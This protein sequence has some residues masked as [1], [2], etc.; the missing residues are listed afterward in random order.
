MAE[1][2]A[3][4]SGQEPPSDTLLGLLARAGLTPADKVGT[5]IRLGA[6][7]QRE[8]LRAGHISDP[9]LTRSV[10][11]WAAL[12]LDAEIAAVLR[13]WSISK[14]ALAQALSL[15][16]IPP[17]ADVD[18][19]AVAPQLGRALK[20]GLPPVSG[21]GIVDLPDLAVVILAD[22]A[23]RGG[24]AGR[25]L[26]SA[27]ADVWV[28]AI[29]LDQA[30]AEALGRPPRLV[31]PP[32]RGVSEASRMYGTC[33]RGAAAGRCRSSSPRPASAPLLP[34][35]QVQGPQRGKSLVREMITRRSAFC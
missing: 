10:A 5:L 17:P 20:G 14:D 32:R 23:M 4:P 22:V 33:S 11:L 25:R 19:I 7:V 31:P 13:L 12:H 30:L 26:E 35:Q 16:E 8:R 1:S 21:T 9:E 18:D 24:L 34:P 27:G 28:A 6:A 3:S 29:G 2:K 15:S